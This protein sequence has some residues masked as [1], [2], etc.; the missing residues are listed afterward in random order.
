D[1]PTV[2]AVHCRIV[3]THA[4]YEIHDAGSTNGTRVAGV[5]VHSAVLTPGVSVVL[6]RTRIVCARDPRDDDAPGSVGAHAGSAVLVGDSIAMERVRQ[7]VERVAAQ[8]FAVLVQ[9][10]TGSGKEVVA[11]MLHERSPRARG[12]FVAINAA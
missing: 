1:D 7:R 6:G 12:P 3:P 4:G 2:S 10:E 8:P 5:R 9:G 11:R